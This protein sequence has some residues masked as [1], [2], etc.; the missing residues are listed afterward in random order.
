MAPTAEVYKNK[1]ILVSV[2][3]EG[4]EAVSS[5]AG[6]EKGGEKELPKTEKAETNVPPPGDQSDKTQLDE[7]P[8]LLPQQ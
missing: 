2:A 5:G 1:M 6:E 3:E 7:T 4:Q 8:P